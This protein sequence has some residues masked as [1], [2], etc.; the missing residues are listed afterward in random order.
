MATQGKC[1]KCRVYFDWKKQIPLNESICV[2]CAPR[3]LTYLQRTAD[4]M[5]TGYRPKYRRIRLNTPP[6]KELYMYSKELLQ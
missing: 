2:F 3:T 5:G 6:L 4:S 1:E